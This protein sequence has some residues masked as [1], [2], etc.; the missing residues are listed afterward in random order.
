M[1]LSR[2][3]TLIF[4]DLNDVDTERKGAVKAL[5]A[6]YDSKLEYLLQ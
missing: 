6:A 3:F 5:I 2:A 1:A 4:A